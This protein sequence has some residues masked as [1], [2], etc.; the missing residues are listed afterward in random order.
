MPDDDEEGPST[1]SKRK[2]GVSATLPPL[3]GSTAKATKIRAEDLLYSRAERESKRAERK[4]KR[5]VEKEERWEEY[6]D[7]MSMSVSLWSMVS[8]SPH[9]TAPMPTSWWYGAGSICACADLKIPD[10]EAQ[11]LVKRVSP[12]ERLDSVQIRC[13]IGYEAAVGLAKEVGIVLDEY[14]YEAQA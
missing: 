4:R 13:E 10:L 8:F 9:S 2:N 1:P 5:E 14:L 6:V 11:G 12:P 3:P 7:D